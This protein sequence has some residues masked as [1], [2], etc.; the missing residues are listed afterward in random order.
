MFL[1]QAANQGRVADPNITK[2]NVKVLP[3]SRFALQSL[4]SSS[5]GKL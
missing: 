3:V 2:Y 5:S 1:I 4:K